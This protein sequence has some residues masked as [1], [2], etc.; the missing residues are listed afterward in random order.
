MGKTKREGSQSAPSGITPLLEPLMAL[1]RLLE[2]FDN[3]D[4]IIG[5]IAASLLGKPR[6]TAD[7]DA[8]ILLRVEDLPKLVDAS[9]EQGITP[10]IA[11]AEVFARKNRVLLLQHQNSGINIDILLG[12]LPFEIEMNERS[13]KLKIGTLFSFAHS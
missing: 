9:R 2:H 6:F 3:Q 10:R 12:I 4:V 7:L 1:Q 5:G 8:V 13:R 11:D